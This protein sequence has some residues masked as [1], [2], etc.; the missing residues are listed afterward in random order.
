MLVNKW[1][2][3]VAWEEVPHIDEKAKADLLATIPP[4]QKEARSKGIPT[5][6]SGLIY[7]IAES[8]MREAD[9]P[10]PNHWKR[11]YAL[12]TG[13]NWTACVW[14]AEDPASKV[15]HIYSTYKRGQAEPAVHA[16]AIKSR[17][18]WI[19]GVGDAADINKKD[20]R[21]MIAIYRDDYGLDINLPV[22]AVEAGIYKVWIA[23]T[24]GKLKVF[25]SC[26]PWFEEV[27]FYA[28]D[29]KGEIVKKNDHLMDSTRYLLMNGMERAKAVPVQVEEKPRYISP[30]MVGHSWM[31]G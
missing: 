4:Y 19:A 30:D 18:K 25:A 9:F 31:G 3:Q 22:K 27:R 8:D 14:G 16:E 7:P 11:A 12:D 13:W 26:A 2:A 1:Y 10:I 24:Q 5:L 20:G 6:G 17:G 28:R 29:E 15:V 23:L 21:Q